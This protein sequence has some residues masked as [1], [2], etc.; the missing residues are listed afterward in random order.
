MSGLRP[1]YSSI[2]VG[3]GEMCVAVGDA[4]PFLMSTFVRFFALRPVRPPDNPLL[5]QPG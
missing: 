4:T 5:L 2:R 3:A 1:T